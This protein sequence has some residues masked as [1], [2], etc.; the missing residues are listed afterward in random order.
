M[1]KKLKRKIQK[2][3]K[4][5]FTKPWYTLSSG[6]IQKKK[7]NSNQES[8]RLWVYHRPWRKVLGYKVI[9]YPS[10]WIKIQNSF[11]VVRE[12]KIMGMLWTL[13]KSCEPI[14]ALGNFWNP[15][16]LKIW[17]GPLRAQWG[18]KLKY[19]WTNWPSP[20]NKGQ[21]PCEGRE[22]TSKIGFVMRQIKDF[23]VLR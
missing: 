17:V 13:L 15:I 7:K 8:P 16:T 12:P 11:L 18:L 9:T 19:F 5:W 3:D 20:L 1:E 6:P 21:G 23:D 10:F 22:W 2:E 4:R 14:Y